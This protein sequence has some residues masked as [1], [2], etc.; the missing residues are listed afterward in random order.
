MTGRKK[1]NEDDL[2]WKGA[3]ADVRP[4]NR[5][6]HAHAHIHTHTPPARRPLPR[7]SGSGKSPDFSGKNFSG[8]AVSAPIKAGREIDRRTAQRLRRGELEIEATIDLHGYNRDEA[9]RRLQKALVRAYE[10]GKR[11]VLVITGKGSGK[12]G[13]GGVLRR[14]LSE[15]LEEEPLVRIVLRQEVAIPAHGGAG[16]F[17]VLLRRRLG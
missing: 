5:D 3:V 15:W 16:A 14:C 12:E 4:L 6:L 1:D 13:G 11:C 7:K 10:S 9:R 2:L 8:K 17:Y